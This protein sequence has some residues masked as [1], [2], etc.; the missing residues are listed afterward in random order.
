MAEKLNVEDIL[1]KYPY[2]ISGGQKQRCAIARALIHNPKLILADEPTGALDSHSAT[3][4]L[5]TLHCI[6]KE[7]AATILMVTHDAFAASFASRILFLRDGAIFTE[8]KKGNDTQQ[9]FFAKILNILA[10][11]G[12]DV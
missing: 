5:S 11:M 2:Q 12:G 8:I 7:L 6:N 4:L 10:I 9:M 1:G 3:I